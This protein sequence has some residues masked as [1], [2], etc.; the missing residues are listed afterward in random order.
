MSEKSQILH[1]LKNGE[2]R[3]AIF[4]LFFK[5]FE[6]TKVTRSATMYIV[7]GPEC[8][9]KSSVVACCIWLKLYM[10]ARSCVD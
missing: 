8:W 3:N 7:H 6:N 2:S 4:W 10:P 1:K 5:D 9:Q